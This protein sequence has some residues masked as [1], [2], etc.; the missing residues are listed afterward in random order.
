MQIPKQISFIT[1]LSKR[2]KKKGSNAF[3]K[4]LQRRTSSF[5]DNWTCRW[6]NGTPCA[7]KRET[8][9]PAINECRSEMHERAAVM[10]RSLGGASLLETNRVHDCSSR[11]WPTSSGWTSSEPGAEGKAKCSAG[12]KAGRSRC[13]RKTVSLRFRSIA[14]GES[15]IRATDNGRSAWFSRIGQITGVLPLINRS[16]ARFLVHVADRQPPSADMSQIRVK[17]FEFLWISF[18]TTRRSVDCRFFDDVCMKM[19]LKVYLTRG[20]K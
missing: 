18:R 14:P 19:F 12:D 4:L 15:K 6:E 3:E 5:G 16:S 10:G 8:R 1:A 20:G 11:R 7:C 17:F 9:N 2:K 13:D